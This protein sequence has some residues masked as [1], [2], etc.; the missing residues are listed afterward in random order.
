MCGSSDG[1]R[2]IFAESGKL[3]AY[4]FTSDL[5]KLEELWAPKTIPSLSRAWAVH[6]SEDRVWT[7]RAVFEFSTGRISTE[8]KN[9]AGLND[10]YSP[11]WIGSNRV[12]E[13]ALKNTAA[14]ADEVS[15]ELLQI[16]LWDTNSGSLLATATAPSAKWISASPD[17]LHI[18]EA[19]ADKRVRI[20]N[21]QTLEVE[22]AF[23]VHEDS[24]V[25]VAW[26]P[27][28]PCLATVSRDGLIRVWDLTNLR[29]LEEFITPPD[30]SVYLEIPQNGSELVVHDLNGGEARVRVYTPESFRRTP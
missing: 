2:L 26:H 25:G 29:K 19:G 22:T 5:S 16:A 14:G 4:Q 18:A 3:A 8:I 9:R 13:L 12:A 10:A 17:G 6:P 27:L 21:A 7:G 15:G 28:L 1:A 30:G 20:R 11:V 24:V 23:R